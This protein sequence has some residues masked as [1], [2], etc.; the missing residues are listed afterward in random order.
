M[1]EKIIEVIPA[2]WKK[3]MFKQEPWALIITDRRLLFAKWTQELFKKESEKRK[4]ETKE[5]GGGKLKQFFS[6]MGTS[7]TY[8]KKYYEM[9]PDEIIN[10]HNENF[11]LTPEDIVKVDMKKGRGKGGAIINVKVGVNIGGGGDIDDL[12]T[13]HELIITT[14]TGKMVFTFNTNFGKVRGALN[15]A[16]N[17]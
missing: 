13:P 12:E 3:S 17:V 2:N 6:Q 10:E 4:E 16:F 5:A 11:A 8:Y 1:N 14:K 9:T 7:F 15:Q